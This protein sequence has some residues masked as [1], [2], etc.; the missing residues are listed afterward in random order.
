MVDGSVH[1]LSD[2]TQGLILRYLVSASEGIPVE[3]GTFL[4]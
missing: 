2:Q 4:Q 1:F 3:G